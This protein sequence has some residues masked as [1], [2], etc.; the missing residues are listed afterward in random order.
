LGVAGATSPAAAPFF[1]FLFF[2]NKKKY[3]LNF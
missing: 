2:F 1:S 3:F